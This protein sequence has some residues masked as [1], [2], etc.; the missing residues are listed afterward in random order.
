M[1]VGALR[2]GDDKV[3]TTILCSSRYTN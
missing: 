2:T 3:T 1:Y